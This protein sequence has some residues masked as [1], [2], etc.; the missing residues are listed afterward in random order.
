[1]P[2]VLHSSLIGAR[3]LGK[4]LGLAKIIEGSWYMPS[5]N[6][7]VVK[8]RFEKH[9]GGSKYFPIDSICDVAT[10]LPHMLPSDEVFTNF[11][12]SINVTNTDT[13]IVIYDTNG[14]SA[15]RTWWTLKGI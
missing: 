4:I 3:G 13:P 12:W 11:M 9:I 1:M 5:H 2:V 8:E 15:P 10:D 6:R 14:W 7:D